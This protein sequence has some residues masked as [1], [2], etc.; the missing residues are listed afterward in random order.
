MMRRALLKGEQGQGVVEFALLIPLLLLL[1]FG[2][3]DFSRLTLHKSLLD[4]TARETLRMASVGSTLTSITGRI[5]SLTEPLMGNVSTSIS[6]NTDDQG[7]P[8]TRIIL[9]PSSGGYTMRVYITPVYSSSLTTGQTMRISIIYTLDY[10]TPLS[11]IFGNSANLH[12]VNYSR[13]ESPPS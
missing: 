12:S 8:C 13:L 5:T 4:Q 10:I 11:S 2:I 1:V 9:T 6:Q 7:N 3:V